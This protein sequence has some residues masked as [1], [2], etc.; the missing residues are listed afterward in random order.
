[1]HLAAAGLTD[2]ALHD[3]LI[4]AGRLDGLGGQS[5]RPDW[6]SRRSRRDPVHGPRRA[7]GYRTSRCVADALLVAARHRWPID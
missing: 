3:D 6:T 1:M 7:R 5:W 2:E 4:A